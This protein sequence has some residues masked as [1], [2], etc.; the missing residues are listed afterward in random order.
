MKKKQCAKNNHDFSLRFYEKES[1]RFVILVLWYLVILQFPVGFILSYLE[2]FYVGPKAFLYNAIFLASFNLF[3]MFIIRVI[4]NDAKIKYYL[5]T[6]IL[7]VA[8]EMVYTY[9]NDIALQMVWIFPVIIA[10]LY[11]NKLFMRLTLLLSVLGLV[12]LNILSP[13]TYYPERF[14]DLLLTSVILIFG[15]MAVIYL[16]CKRLLSLRNTIDNTMSAV[17][18]GTSII[19][20]TIKNEITTIDMLVNSLN[21][22]NDEEK[23]EEYLSIIKDSTRHLM[24][25]VDKIQTQIQDI[26]VEPRPVNLSEL[27]KQ[28]ISKFKKTTDVKEIS[29]ES[30]IEDNIDMIGDPIHLREMFFNLVRN[31]LEAIEGE[32]RVG[33]IEVYL[34]KY[35]SIALLTVSDNG[36]GIPKANLPHIVDPFFSSKRNRKNNYGLGLTYCYNVIKAHNGTL[37]IESEE[38]KRTCV[39]I[40]LPLKMVNN[41]SYQDSASLTSSRRADSKS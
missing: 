6:L 34:K 10:S 33:S 35:G 31:A 25:M 22:T 39:K 40:E 11:F 15:L 24:L 19:N 17:T 2:F 13:I 37:D 8:G 14:H 21:T 3:F 4:K 9:I 26:S 16:S 12:L 28:C 18:S 23:K 32:K 36:C 41:V 30:H 29:V 5:M 20:H 7:V 27:V 38:K 1:N